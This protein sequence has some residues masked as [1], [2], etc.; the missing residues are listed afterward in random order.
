MTDFYRRKGLIPLPLIIAIPSSHPRG[1]WNLER[2]RGFLPM[3]RR[4]ALNLLKGASPILVVSRK[5]LPACNP[6]FPVPPNARYD[7]QVIPVVTREATAALVLGPVVLRWPCKIPLTRPHSPTILPLPYLITKTLRDT[8]YNHRPVHC[9]VVDMS[10]WVDG[11]ILPVFALMSLGFFNRG[12]YALYKQ[13]SFRI[14]KNRYISTTKFPRNL[15]QT[16]KPYHT[17]ISVLMRQI[18]T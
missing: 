11:R 1:I 14:M 9:K 7:H 12:S 18:L 8:Y 15:T 10:P 6:T 5:S 3:P 4:A 16:L 13:A 2:V 17:S